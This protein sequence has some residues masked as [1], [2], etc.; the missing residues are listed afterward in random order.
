MKEGLRAE[1]SARLTC[2]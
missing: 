2:T 1:L